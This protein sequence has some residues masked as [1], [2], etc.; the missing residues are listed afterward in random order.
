MDAPVQDAPSQPG[1]G[2]ILPDAAGAP[3]SA[4]VAAPEQDAAVLRPGVPDDAGAPENDADPFDAHPRDSSVGEAAVTDG[5]GVADVLTDGAAMDAPADG[6]QCSGG[7]YCSGACTA[8]FSD[9]HNC[10][11]CAHDCLGAACSAGS[12]VGIPIVTQY[13][14]NRPIA[15]DLDRVYFTAQ[16]NLGSGT[17]V[18]SVLKVGGSV[19]L[20][21]TGDVADGIAVDDT[22]VYY[23][24][25]LAGQIR[26]V[27]K[28]GSAA[29]TTL[30]S[31]ATNSVLGIGIDATYVYYS[32][33]QA[34]AIYR[35]AKAGGAVQALTTNAGRAMDLVVDAS[36][37]YFFDTQP[38]TVAGELRRVAL[39]GAGGVF[40][41]ASSFAATQLAQGATDVVYI[42]GY[43]M[44]RV[45]KAGG[46][47]HPYT[48]FSPLQ[49]RAVAAFGDTAFY[50]YTGSGNPA[51][52]GS[53]NLSA[54]GSSTI[55]Y[56]SWTEWP[57][58]L[59]V[60]DATWIYF[61]TNGKIERVA[62]R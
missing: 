12:C 50:A 20:L 3:G 2:L 59:A 30:A 10:G 15:L 40:T 44:G 60:N 28:D 62:Q 26:R 13:A 32:D 16:N 58:Q 17:G 45:P 48:E 34:N 41:L 36:G 31:G 38:G 39:D 19:T 18:A 54:S 7:I 6:T 53:V 43:E 56:T 27:P 24:E 35:V 25:H 22:F 11:S 5:D 23:A 46:G 52:I 55:A 8:W 49:G 42:S 1:G 37:V 14:S 4:G 47:S 21:A 9:P 29:P 61:V 51:G 57:T 33:A